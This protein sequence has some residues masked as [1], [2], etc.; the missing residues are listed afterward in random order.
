MHPYITAAGGL[1]IA[2]RRWAGILSEGIHYAPFIECAADVAAA[3]D[4]ERLRE[5]AAVVDHD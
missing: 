2:L 5:V 1:L 3:F 4:I